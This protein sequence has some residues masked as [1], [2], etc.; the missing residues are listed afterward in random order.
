MRRRLV[1]WSLAVAVAG[2]V[3]G[4]RDAR[5]QA[6]TLPDITPGRSPGGQDSSMGSPPGADAGLINNLPGSNQPILGGRPGSSTPRLAPPTS[7]TS[8]SL[9][10]GQRI[11]PTPSLPAL[12]I[13]QYGPLS[14][15]GGP[16]D[17]GPADGLTLD[18]AIERLVRENLDLRGKFME[19]PQADAD[20]LTASL[21]NNPV[22]YADSQ[23]VPYGQFSRSRPGGP[24]QFDVNVSFPFD[25]NR[26]RK[27]RMEVAVRAKKVLEAMYQDAVRL[28]IDNLY[29]S[30]VDVLNSR[31]TIRYAEVSLK[32]LDQIVTISEA[33]VRATSL[34]EAEADRVRVQRDS[35]QIF[36]NE[37]REGLKKAQR[38]LATLLNIPPTQ[39]TT[40]AIRGSIRNTRPEIPSDDALIRM[41]VEE[42]PDLVANRLG[43]RRA[44]ADVDLARKN[45]FQDVYLLAQPYTFQ[46]NQPYGV[47]S[48]YSYAVGV[49]VTLPI[50]NR[51][52]GNIRRAEL[53][54]AQT[55]TEL[56]TLE[57]Q[58]VTDVEQAIAEYRTSMEAIKRIEATVL[59]Q[60]QE[61]L[62]T[63]RK[64]L[65]TGA[66]DPLQFLNIQREYN[67]V[68]RQYRDA[69]IR[70]RRSMLDL[71]TAVGR[72]LLP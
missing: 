27:A 60:A 11:R 5:A 10:G 40:I 23:L 41:A 47:K 2:M 28:Q 71:N 70:H 39:A 1:R 48:A 7:A 51:N 54:V 58:A 62:K 30:F 46:N 66:L 32:G 12:E 56:A 55:R 13:P 52:Q 26:K 34:T 36:L 17:E 24:E 3:A 29:T 63:Y 42:R 53:N 50:A 68:V 35:A 45:R 14:L 57:R 49:T 65:E 64:Q 72:R 67:D 69:L 33:K 22:F 6:P 38:V 43:V 8:T 31:E 37:Q 61:V 16:E 20:I 4:P 21:R 9:T 44:V 25:V 15:P 59:N 19:I 18:A